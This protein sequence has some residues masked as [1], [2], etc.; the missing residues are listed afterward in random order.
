MM[1]ERQPCVYSPWA[2]LEWTRPWLLATHAVGTAERF[3]QKFHSNPKDTRACAGL[4]C[5]ISPNACTCR[6]KRERSLGAG[7]RQVGAGA[8]RHA[9]IYASQ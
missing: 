3:R 4:I 1:T 8:S 5:A 7:C 9:V 6:E 2:L